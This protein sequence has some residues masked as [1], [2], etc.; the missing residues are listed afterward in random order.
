MPITIEAV[1][2]RCVLRL[3]GDIDI[4]GA[5]ELKAA[6]IEAFSSRKEVRVDLQRA[7]DFDITAVQLLWA[8]VRDAGKAGVSFVVAGQTTDTLDHAASE[9]GLA[10]LGLQVVADAPAEA[11]AAAPV[12]SADDR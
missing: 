6:L 8:A 12:K 5:A 3:E 1:D 11:S 9:M 10:N 2:G 4:A 7:T